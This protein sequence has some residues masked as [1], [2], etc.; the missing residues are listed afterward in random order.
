MTV[1]LFGKRGQANDPVRIQG[2]AANA[3][4]P[5]ISNPAVV[6]AGLDD[7]GVVRPLRTEQGTGNIATSVGGQPRRCSLFQGFAPAAGATDALLTFTNQTLS[8]CSFL[9]SSVGGVATTVR[10]FI[11]DTGTC[12][13]PTGVTNILSTL[14][15]S[16][17]PMSYSGGGISPIF[18]VFST[19]QVCVSAGAGASVRGT[20]A[21]VLQ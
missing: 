16:T 19:K 5:A 15:L 11:A 4:I 8:I 1:K 21:Y 9:A 14:D 18:E 7:N 13:A 10:L 12:A 20:F 2:Q 6:I 17:A 3:A